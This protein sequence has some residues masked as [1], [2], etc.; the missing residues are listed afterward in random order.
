MA[1]KKYTEFERKMVPIAK[2]R[3]DHIYELGGPTFNQ[4]V[5]EDKT[6]FGLMELYEHLIEKGII[7]KFDD[8][9]IDAHYGI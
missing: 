2:R 5:Y 3:C 8:S 1:R 7:K 6:Y 9:I 4:Y